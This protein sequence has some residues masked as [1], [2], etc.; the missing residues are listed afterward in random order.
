VSI[1]PLP[2]SK[3]QQGGK[4]TRVV[5]GDGVVYPVDL[6]FL[7]GNHIA[8]EDVS[9]FAC[10]CHDTHIVAHSAR[11]WLSL[12]RRSASKLLFFIF[13]RHCVP[14]KGC[15]QTRGGNFVKFQVILGI[16]SPLEREGN[17]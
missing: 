6:W 3:Q 5:G 15:N 11:F 10:I 4:K 9:R 17:S 8:P 1:K 12:Y 2:V 13:S 16:F 14:K 7:I